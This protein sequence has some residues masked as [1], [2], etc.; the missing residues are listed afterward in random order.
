MSL[1]DE[2][3]EYLLGVGKATTTEIAEEVGRPRQK[4]S[5]V[6]QAPQFVRLG[7]DKNGVF[8][9]VKMRVSP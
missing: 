8:Y 1:A 3:G 4:V 7:R 6:L 2:V 5:A 9:G